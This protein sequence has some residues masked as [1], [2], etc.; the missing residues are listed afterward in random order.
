MGRS[1]GQEYGKRIFSMGNMGYRLIKIWIKCGLILYFSRIK[2]YGLEHV[3]KDKPVLFL[4][5]HQNALL[6]VLLIA[7][8]CNR[9][10]YF[11]TRSDVFKK[12]LLKRFFKFLRMIPIYR[13]RDGRESLKNNQAVFKEC[14]HL[15]GKNEAI[16]MFPE[17]NHNLKRRV[18]PLSKGFTRIL[19]AALEHNTD[20][21]IRLV[22]VGLNYQHAEGFPDRTAIFFGKDIPVR[23]LYDPGN[24]GTTA[25]SL[26]Q[27]VSRSLKCLTTHVENE[28]DYNKI[29]GILDKSNTDYLSPQ[30][31]NLQIK[32]M[33]ELSKFSGKG[34]KPLD[35]PSPLYPI[36]LLL[37][38]PV[39]LLW[40]W[41]L[42]PRVWEPEFTATLRFALA[43]LV[44]P[45]YYVVLLGILASIF[46]A[47][48]AVVSIL[49]IFLF[50]LLYVRLE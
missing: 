28:D 27:E 49:G 29:I 35:K 47:A 31:V 41:V 4:P 19:F 40:R 20:L 8:D 5:N 21:D 33:K 12:P 26:K 50:N 39:V 38:L 17:A 44:Y 46:G 25:D 2:I 11:L 10:P 9:K 34:E 42:R 1:I 36:F 37:N 18:R 24:L 14:A 16:L 15:L 13:I 48:I 22:P 7:V 3:P 30:K 43:L 23:P 32:Q 6:D 45:L